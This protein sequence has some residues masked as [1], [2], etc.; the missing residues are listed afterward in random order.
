M[1]RIVDL[2][3]ATFLFALV[4]D[5]LTPIDSEEVPWCVETSVGVQRVQLSRTKTRIFEE[6][7]TSMMMSHIAWGCLDEMMACP[8]IL[9]DKK[10]P[11]RLKGKF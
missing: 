7:V 9:C 1:G 11:S 4:M 3:L 5:E 2:F 8:R 10:I 6:V